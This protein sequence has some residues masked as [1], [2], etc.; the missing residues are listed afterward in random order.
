MR[1]LLVL[2]RLLRGWICR[3]PLLPW[4][5]EILSQTLTPR[6]SALG[7][8]SQRRRWWTTVRLAFT[9]GLSAKPSAGNPFL[10]QRFLPILSEECLHEILWWVLNLNLVRVGS[11]PIRPRPFDASI[12]GYIFSDASDLGSGAVLFTKGPEAAA[13]SVVAA[14]AVAAPASLS[15]AEIVRQA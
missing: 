14:L 4:K 8:T 15:R 1:P 11:G 13:S 12:D 7:S 10:R 5:Q 3:S 6:P 2:R 9:A